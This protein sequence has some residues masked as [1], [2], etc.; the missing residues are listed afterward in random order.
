MNQS[1]FVQAIGKV[2]LGIDKSVF[3]RTA[4]LRLQDL[5]ITD[6]GALRDRLNA[7][8]TTGDES[9]AEKSLTE[10][11]NALR[12]KCRHNRTGLLPQAEREREEILS[13]IP[14][15]KLRK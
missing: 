8:V 7:L 9:G 6:D 12:N 5:P 2:L 4:F 13:T 14:A 11:L 15:P 10:N 3:T 1:L